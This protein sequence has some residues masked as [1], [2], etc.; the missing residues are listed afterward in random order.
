MA[1]EFGEPIEL[2]GRRARR[3][4]EQPGEARTSPTVGITKLEVV[5]HYLACGDG[6]LRALR[7]R[8]DHPRALARGSR[9]GRAHL[10]ARGLQGRGVLPEARAAGRSVVRRDRAHHVPVGAHRRRDRADHAR[11]RSRGPRSSARSPSTRGRCAGARRRPPR[12][13]APRPR[14]AARHATSRRRRGG[15]RAARAARRARHGRVAQDVAAAAACTSTCGSSRGGS[16]STCGTPRSP[17][18][19][20]SSGGCPAASPPSGGRRSGRTARSSSTTTRTR[21]TARSPRRTPSAPSRTRRCRCRCRWDELDDVTPFDFTVRTAGAAL[22]RG[23]RPA[24]RASTTRRTT[25]R[26]CSSGTPAT[27]PTARRPALPAGLPE[28]GRR[29]QAGAAQ[30]GQGPPEVLTLRGGAMT[31]SHEPGTTRWQRLQVPGIRH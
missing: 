13:A 10:H 3:A 8:P 19:A 31:P 16:S 21:A 6:I 26:R 12:R 17:S 29:A 30:Q 23:G 15:A 9:R 14:P 1:K 2:D 7:E 4:G 20:S 18:A 22:R 24:R 25:S 28:D 11:G 27:R 5:Q